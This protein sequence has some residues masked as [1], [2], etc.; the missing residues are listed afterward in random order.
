MTELYC[1]KSILESVTLDIIK[2]LFGFI[3][4]WFITREFY[5]R[6]LNKQE[7]KE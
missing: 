7:A 2:I 1:A 3:I 6:R 4:G 5:L